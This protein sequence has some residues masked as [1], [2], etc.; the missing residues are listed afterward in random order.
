MANRKRKKALSSE[1][2]PEILA[3]SQGQRTNR[4]L[5]N[6][7]GERDVLQ[8][9]GLAGASAMPTVKTYE[10][11]HGV[12]A[13]TD[14][15]ADRDFTNQPRVIVI[16]GFVN[17]WFSNQESVA[18]SQVASALSNEVLNIYGQVVR[19]I[20]SKRLTTIR[21]TILDNTGDPTVPQNPHQY[22][23]MIQ[24]LNLYS[25][26]FG[27][28]RCLE[29]VYR[30]GTFN[31]V[32]NDMSAT[33]M[34]FRP[35]VEGLL[36]GLMEIPVPP[37]LVK[38]LD[39][40]TGVKVLDA[41]SP[42]RI[43]VAG[44]P[45]D[46]PIAQVAIDLRSATVW[47]NLLTHAEGTLNNLQNATLAAQ[48]ADFRRIVNTFALAYGYGAI[49]PKKE[50]SREPGEYDIFTNLAVVWH[51]VGGA[52]A[53]G[54]YG[55]PDLFYVASDPV[56]TFI[57][58]GTSVEASRQLLSFFS[59]PRRVL[60]PGAVRPFIPFFTDEVMP[61]VGLFQNPSA[62]DWTPAGNPGTVY[63]V[64]TSAG[65]AFHVLSNGDMEAGANDGLATALNSGPIWQKYIFDTT[66]VAG[67]PNYN[68]DGR[69]FEQ[70]D[71]VKPTIS[72]L[73]SATR[74]MLLTMFLEGIK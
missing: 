73:F 22:Q 61:A 28:T 44:L 71:I 40:M 24:W 43:Y 72:E 35:R 57:R 51:Q 16:P 62:V 4:P 18:P 69:Q 46:D 45:T 63:T 66:M 27:I 32:L 17:W 14:W 26:V 38:V 21:D 41:D 67:N 25:C 20:Q 34:Q 50:I 49:F 64:I 2:G 30:A 6:R 48:A 60:T 58:K 65:A 29:S 10:M 13:S 59:T 7:G 15:P 3:A 53:P 36:Q 8:N 11:A 68:I 56:P 19:R 74:Y 23:A 47:S 42:A 33:G 5:T 37:G 39:A 12:T 31:S 54:Y 70:Y 1:A 9:I 55:F 52:V